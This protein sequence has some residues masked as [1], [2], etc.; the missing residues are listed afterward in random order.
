LAFQRKKIGTIL[1]F[2]Q[3]IDDCSY[4]RIETKELS[5][6]PNKKKPEKEY[7]LMSG[8][9]PLPIFSSSDGVFKVF[10]CLSLNRSVKYVKSYLSSSI[11]ANLVKPIFWM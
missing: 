8:M 10:N 6:G 5:A 1:L 3:I 4:R 11:K 7:H 9:K 2:F